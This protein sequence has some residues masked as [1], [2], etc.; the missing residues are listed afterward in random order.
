MNSSSAIDNSTFE[1]LKDSMGADFIGEIVQTYVE[2]MPK[3]IA[4]LQEALAKQDCEGFRRAAHSI[5]STSNSLGALKFGELAKELEMISRECNLASAPEKV[6]VLVS[7]YA[8]VKQTLEGLSHG[9][10][11]HLTLV[12]SG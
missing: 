9:L 7:D 12:S 2:E 8:E 4:Q 6:K 5:K 11:Q 1:A 10:Y 3:L